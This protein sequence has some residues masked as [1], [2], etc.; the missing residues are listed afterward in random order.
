M[1]AA[2]IPADPDAHRAFL[3]RFYGLSRFIYDATRKYY[4]LGRDQLLEE[5]LAEPWTSLVEVGVGTARNLR[6]LHAHRPE[7]AYGGIEPCDEMRRHAQARAPWARIVDAFAESADYRAIL[8]RSPDRILFSYS[9]S[10]ISDPPAALRRAAE[11]LVQ[12]GEVAV[13][14]FGRLAS[15]ESRGRAFRRF[16]AT[17]H[18]EPV[19][20]SALGIPPRNVKE[21][22]FGYC[23]SARFGAL[24][25]TMESPD[26]A[27][28]AP[29]ERARGSATPGR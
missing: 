4:L 9:L 27:S 25:P 15:F 5:L 12:G 3:N 22:P 18:V 13:V 20:C 1:R 19:D 16:L 23:A 26:G 28:Q 14:D 10:M 11:S 2:S 17:F 6:K 7:A 29:C 21:G 8:G 24:P